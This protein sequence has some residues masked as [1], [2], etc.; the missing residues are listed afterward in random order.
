VVHALSR[1]ESEELERLGVSVV[2]GPRDGA[3]SC[4][5][6]GSPSDCGG[7]CSGDE[8][9]PER[10]VPTTWDWSLLRKFNDF[11]PST[12]SAPHDFPWLGDLVTRERAWRWTSQ[13]PRFFALVEASDSDIIRAFIARTLTEVEPPSDGDSVPAKGC[14]REKEPSTPTP[15]DIRA[16]AC[17]DENQACQDEDGAPFNLK[18]ICCF[19]D[20]GGIDCTPT[21]ESFGGRDQPGR[22]PG[23]PPEVSTA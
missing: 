8:A 22:P 9:L 19:N 6:T 3:G 13:F 12:M 5:C 18:Q 10:E 11:W 1:R 14:C 17:Y 16:N 4:D 23:S 2:H 15:I 7:P 21:C 20:N